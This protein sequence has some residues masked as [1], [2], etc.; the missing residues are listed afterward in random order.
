MILEKAYSLSHHSE[1]S[2]LHLL[3][4]C[5]GDILD[6][7]VVIEDDLGLL[8]LSNGSRG[9]RGNRHLILH[10]GRSVD[11]LGSEGTIEVLLLRCLEMMWD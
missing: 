9:L 8:G 4:N 7:L 2:L 6:Q 11:G 5:I 1:D 3:L 10:V